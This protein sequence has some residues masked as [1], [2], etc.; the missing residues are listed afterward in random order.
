M[1]EKSDQPLPNSGWVSWELWNTLQSH[2]QLCPKEGTPRTKA[3]GEP[4]SSGGQIY[5]GDSFR[6]QEI[7]S[8]M[9]QHSQ[10]FNFFSL[11]FVP[12]CHKYIPQLIQPP[13]LKSNL[14]GFGSCFKYWILDSVGLKILSVCFLWGKWSLV[15]K[16]KVCFGNLLCKDLTEW[17]K[18][19]R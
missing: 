3:K 15:P 6:F 7:K 12:Q 10:N 8:R 18:Q 13:C 5:S 9:K 1:V 4:A 16:V 2:I 11:V 19:N 14:Q 17:K